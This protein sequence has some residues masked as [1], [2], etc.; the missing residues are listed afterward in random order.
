VATY[1]IQDTKVSDNDENAAKDD[2][3][4]ENTTY[5]V[6]D[7]VEVP[8]FKVPRL[9]PNSKMLVRSL[10]QQYPPD[11]AEVLDS[12]RRAVA[13][14]LSTESQSIP[15]D[16]PF[17]QKHTD[18]VT[19]Q[20]ISAE[21]AERRERL[22]QYASLDSKESMMELLTGNARI[23]LNA[24]LKVQWLAAVTRKLKRLHRRYKGNRSPTDGLVNM[25]RK[26]EDIIRFCAGSEEAGRILDKI[27]EAIPNVKRE[28]IDDDEFAALDDGSA[29]ITEYFV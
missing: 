27:D 14:A 24:R 2:G 29:D 25:I 1:T 10:H 3:A 17:V 23:A 8:Y 11:L 6:S 13:Y 5:E 12:V 21:Q 15:L 9:A 26:Y 4:L 28:K 19:R 22:E 20:R 7:A 16:D 18:P